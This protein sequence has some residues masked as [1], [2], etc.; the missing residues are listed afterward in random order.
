MQRRAFAF[1][2]RLSATANALRNSKP[3]CALLSPVDRAELRRRRHD[4]ASCVRSLLKPEDAGGSFNTTAAA[5]AALKGANSTISL[6]G[7]TYGDVYYCSGQSNSKL[8]SYVS[9]RF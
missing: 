5:A 2:Y 7:V 4:E 8:L 3:K 9:Y 1:A 6:H